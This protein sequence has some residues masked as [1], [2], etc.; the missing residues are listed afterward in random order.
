MDSFPFKLKKEMVEGGGTSL[1]PLEFLSFTYQGLNEAAFECV[2]R[3]VRRDGQTVRLV[4]FCYSKTL[5]NMIRYGEL[6]GISESGSGY[7][8][9]YEDSIRDDGTY[10]SEYTVI[11]YLK[12][13]ISSNFGRLRMMIP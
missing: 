9:M 8:D 11:Y 1:K 7:G 10:A 12:K 13:L 3:T 2:T 6:S 4:C 5:W